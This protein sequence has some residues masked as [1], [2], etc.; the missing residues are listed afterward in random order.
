MKS[1]T[2]LVSPSGLIITGLRG[3]KNHT[4]IDIQEIS[5]CAAEPGVHQRIF[6]WISRDEP[7]GKMLCHAVLCSSKEKARAMSIVLSRMFQF[8]YRDWRS[9]K[10]KERL[11]ED[12]PVDAMDSRSMDTTGKISR[13][14]SS[15]NSQ[16]SE[17][18]VSLED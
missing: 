5:Y 1:V 14:A 2:I 3:A 4:L 18:T 11:T 10:D 6:S 13:S 7:G 17:Q 8:A 15:S 9:T 12:E 16:S